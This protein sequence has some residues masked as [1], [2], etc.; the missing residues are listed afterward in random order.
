MLNRPPAE[1]GFSVIELMVTFT[2]LAMLLFF[3]LPQYYR[4]LQNAQVR[5]FAEGVASG[6]Q[7]ARTEA[8]SRNV[9]GGVTF[10]LNDDEWKVYPTST[11]TEVLRSQRNR[12]RTPNA[13]WAVKVANAAQT[14]PVALVFD[15]FGRLT[16]VNGA[17]PAGITAFEITNSSAGACVKD[18]GDTRCLDVRVLASGSIRMC[19]PALNIAT[20]PQG[21]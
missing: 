11:A 21:C 1:R 3:G 12:E 8:V 10:E 6:L 2:V 5:T 4:F 19:D 14:A 9:A 17:A 15:G 18:S 13:T 7:F 16:S 20:N